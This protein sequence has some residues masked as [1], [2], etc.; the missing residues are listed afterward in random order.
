MIRRTG[1][2]GLKSTT[3][4][5]RVERS[6]PDQMLKRSICQELDAIIGERQRPQLT[7]TRRRTVALKSELLI[8]T[9]AAG[10][11]SWRKIGARPRKLTGTKRTKK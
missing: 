2:G 11:E 8:F 3:A 9:T 6:E 1:K 7:Q 4:S 5:R 10:I